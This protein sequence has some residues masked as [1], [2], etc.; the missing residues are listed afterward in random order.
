MYKLQQI[1]QFTVKR[2][3][4]AYSFGGQ[5]SNIKV[6]SGLFLLKV[7]RK[8]LPWLFQVLVA[9]RVLWLVDASL[10][11][12]P[13]FSHCLLCMSVC[14]YVIG[15]GVHLYNSG[16]FHLVIFN[17]IISANTPLSKKGHIHWF[18]VVDI[19]FRGPS[20]NPQ[21]ISTP[22]P[23]YNTHNCSFYLAAVDQ[24]F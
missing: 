19:S 7:P 14:L 5:K 12:L 11:S 6:L 8:I 18:G 10:W 9:P 4:F 13:Q 22:P 20:F 2:K 24:A 21:Q 3:L 15:F 23:F 17:L 1:W 16:W